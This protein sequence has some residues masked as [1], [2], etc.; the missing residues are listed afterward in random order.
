MFAPDGLV[1]AARRTCSWSR[2]GRAYCPDP[3]DPMSCRSN[4][5]LT[6]TGAAAPLRPRS[7]LR[8]DR[9]HVPAA[10]GGRELGVLRRGTGRA[11]SRRATTRRAGST[12]PRTRARTHCP[13]S[14]PSHENGQQ[15]NI[16]WHDAFLEAGRRRHAA[17][18]CRGSCRE[19]S[20]SEHPGSD[21]TV[22][23]G[24]AYV[25]KLVN[26]AMRGPDWDSTA[27]FLTWDDWGGFYDHV[28]PPSVD[29]NGYGM[30]VPGIVISPVGRAG[31]R[32]TRRCSFDAYLK[33]I[34]DRFLGGQ[35][36]DPETDGRPDSRPTVREDVRDPGRSR[37]RVRLHAGAVTPA[38][39]GS[40]PV[41]AGS[42]LAVRGRAGAQ[43]D[44][45]PVLAVDLRCCRG[46]RPA[47]RRRVRRT[48]RRC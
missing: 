10:Q 4:L 17:R 36:L 8:V 20:A 29:G 26:A 13:D 2:P 39:P 11:R 22:G 18:R 48:G 28:E 30:R 3:A 47:R 31:D 15:R 6:E 27:I 40:H 46:P 32:L 9:H 33:L 38:D 1:D 23:D 41:G 19:R 7:D 5:D 35:R 25:T 34:E 37:R 44:V 14:R 12:A 45:A 21:S 43:A 16:R 42:P 24:Q